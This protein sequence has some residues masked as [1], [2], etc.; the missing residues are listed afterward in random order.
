MYFLQ[1]KSTFV[2]DEKLHRVIGFDH[3]VLLQLLHYPT[4]NIFIDAI[5]RITSSTFYQVFF[6]IVYEYVWQ[7]YVPV[8]VILMTWKT[9][10]DY[11]HEI[12][13]MITTSQ[14]KLNPK[15]ITCDFEKALI[16]SAKEHLPISE[17]I[18]VCSILSR[19]F[20]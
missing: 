9:E 3:P 19:Y 20:G 1:F 11:W 10:V 17:N 13:W 4:F 18:V 8:L 14:R 5:F 15:K 2:V 7:M 6:L 16:N 12:L